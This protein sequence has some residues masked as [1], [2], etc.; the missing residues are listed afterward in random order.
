MVPHGLIYTSDNKLAYIA[1]RI[2]RKA[3]GNKIHMEDFCQLSERLTED[4]YKGSYEQCAKVIQ[5][6]SANPG[7]DIS[8]LFYRLVFCFITGNSDMH[9][10][11]FSLIKNGA[12]GAWTLSSAY[13][14]L[15]VNLIMKEDK[16]ETALTLNGKKSRL[17][18]KDFLAFATT[19]N[20]PGKAAEKMISKLIS[21]AELFCSLARSPLLPK[22]NQEEFVNLIKSRIARLCG[23]VN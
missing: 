3:D 10:K 9:L 8:E 12:D 14:M 23:T 17:Q 7:L 22:E 13:D 2:D 6:Y 18:K 21:Q 15:A 19:V 4:K 5:L 20:I 1:R 11:N 16:E